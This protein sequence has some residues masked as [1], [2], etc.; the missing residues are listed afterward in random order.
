MSEVAR[1]E[2][3]GE[4]LLDSG[5]TFDEFEQLFTTLFADEIAHHRTQRAYVVA[6]RLFLV[7]ELDVL[8]S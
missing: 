7:R 2:N 8:A 4:S 3:G 5:R 1:N 6:E